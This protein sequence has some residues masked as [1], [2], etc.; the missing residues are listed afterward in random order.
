MN[1]DEYTVGPGRPPRK[2]QFQKGRSGNPAGRP[3]GRPNR[4]TI[5]KLYNELFFECEVTVNGREGPRRT[6]LYA[7]MLML[8]SQK[9][10]AGD[11]GAIEKLSARIESRVDVQPVPKADADRTEDDGEILRQYGRSGL[12]SISDGDEAGE[13]S[14]SH[15]LEATDD[16]DD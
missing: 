5:D 15:R 14:S 7:A 13:E 12:I 6:S 4:K 9:A 8:W 11:P 16:D 1:D 3:K 2:N 10:L